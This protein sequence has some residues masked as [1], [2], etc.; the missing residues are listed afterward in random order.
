MLK[1][2]KIK[3]RGT[4]K[5]L[6]ATYAP[7]KAAALLG[8]PKSSILA[9]VKAG[10]LPCIRWNRR[11]FRITATDLAI[12]YASKGGRLR[13]STTCTSPTTPPSA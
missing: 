11:T 10:V 1:E 7:S 9:A 4:M 5:P 8:I 12:W 6:I 13:N 3:K 2:Q